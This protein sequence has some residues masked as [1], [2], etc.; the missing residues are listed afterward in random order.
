MARFRRTT[1][2]KNTYLQYVRSYRNELKQP[3]TEVI[4][5]LGNISKMSENDIERLTLSFIK[6]VKMEDKFQMNHFNAGKAYHYG[7]CLPVIAIWNKLGLDEIINNS[8]PKKVTIPVSKVSLIQTSNR[9]SDPGSKLAC[10]RWH[11]LSMFSQIKDF[12]SLQGDEQEKLHTYYRSLEYLCDAKEKIEEELYY[13]LNS[14]GLDNR[15]VLY[16]ITSVYFEGSQSEIGKKGYSRDKRPDAEQVVIGLVMSRDGIPIAHHVFEGNRTDKTTVGEVIK[17]LRERFSITEIVFVGDRGMLTVENI[18]T[19]KSKGNNYILGMQK[20]NRRI[21]RYLLERIDKE[22]EIQEIRY[23][24]LSEGFKKE[25]SEGVRF[26]ACY[27]IEMAKLNKDSRERNIRKFENL[28]KETELKGRLDKIKE[29]H[30]KLKSFL[31]KYHITNFYNLTIEKTTKDKMTQLKDTRDNSGKKEEYNIQIEKAVSVILAEAI[32]EGRFFIQTEVNPQEFNKEEIVKSYKS[33]QKVEQAFKVIK[34]EFD[35]RPVYLRKGNR[36][37]GHVMIC[38]LALLVNILLDKK[39]QEV[40]PE[41]ENAQVRKANLKKSKH[42]SDDPLTMKTLMEELDT[43]RLI[44]LYING[45][46]RPKYISTQ[47]GKNLRKLFSSLGI[48][49]AMEPEKLR[50]AAKKT[51]IGYNQLELLF[52]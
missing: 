5:N 25:Y 22:V 39:M 19:V 9:F 28:I 47:I 29:S 4:A 48:V 33:L 51:T 24:D 23:A 31:S 2:K 35:I 18:D 21:I 40:F 41:M 15:L 20:R 10:Y 11:S 30:Y 27:N 14:Y 26:I 44:P 17:D 43:I 46:E 50:L 16:D 6:A 42:S 36:I 52:T 13:R 12:I 37:K 34:N 49:N 32:L 1:A 8:L 45:N 38:Y 7:T 3:T